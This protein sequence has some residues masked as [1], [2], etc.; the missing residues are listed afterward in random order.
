MLANAV[1]SLLQHVRRLAA[2]ASSDEQLLADFLARRSDEAFS[3]LLGRHGPMV[4]NVCRRILHDAHAAE[5]VFQATFLVL[6]DRAGA[7]HRPASLA[8]FLHGV[9]YRLAVRARRRRMQSLPAARVRQ[10]RWASGRAGLEG[11]A[12]HS[13]PRAGPAVGPL[14]R[15]AG[16]LLPGGADAGRGGPAARLEPQH[17]AAAVG[18]GPAT[19]RSA[20][21]RPG[22]HAAGGPGGTA[23]RECRRRAR[24]PAGG[25][26]G[27]GRRTGG[28]WSYRRRLRP[29]LGPEWDHPLALHIGQEDRGL[30]RG[31]GPGE[32]PS[33]SPTAGPRT[34]IKPRRE[35]AHPEVA[36]S[37]TV[38]CE[39]IPRPTR[40]RPRVAVR[41]GTARYRHGSRI[42]SM[43][44]SAD[45]KLAVTASGNSPYNPALAGRFSPARVF[46]LT[47]GRCLYSLPNERGASTPRPWACPRTGRSWPPRTSRF[48]YFRDAATGKEL[49][50]I[51]YLPDSGGGAVAH[52]LVDVHAGRQTGR[53]HDDGRRAVQLD[54][55]GD[56]QGDQDVRPGAAA[57]ACVFSPD[58]KLMATGG[59]EQ[60]NGVYFARLWEV[61][62]GKELR[63]FAIGRELNRPIGSARVLA[64]R[65]DTRRRLLGRRAAPSL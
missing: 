37:R 1:P 19:A 55:R 46:D 30:R 60:E 50:K 35:R 16:A 4:L 41:L 32:P 65:D 28:R 57:R 45:G 34:R 11:D 53:G 56:R 8:G 15:P 58:G 27:R 52:R 17:A 10:G 29:H 47:D 5:D 42:E 24:P 48:L 62:T 43:A 64:R 22:R 39:T 6:A 38:R 7:I 26:A 14:S 20:P 49:R 23:G 18:A 21:P 13:G 54:R 25:D 44:V 61:A 40:S 2:T 33:V 9:A 51:K 3:A 59:Y 12:R 31:G 36:A 63:R